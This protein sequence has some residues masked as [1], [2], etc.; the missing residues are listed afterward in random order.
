[1]HCRSPHQFADGTMGEVRTFLTA[2]TCNTDQYCTALPCTVLYCTALHVT[3][4]LKNY[5]VI[6]LLQND[7]AR[8]SIVSSRTEWR[9]IYAVSV[10]FLRFAILFLPLLSIILVFIIITTIVHALFYTFHCFS[11]FNC[12]SAS[13]RIDSIDCWSISHKLIA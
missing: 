11:H 4:Q 8:Y 13:P 1:M 7:T 2:V 5:C 10:Q 3:V 6:C 12:L 9:S